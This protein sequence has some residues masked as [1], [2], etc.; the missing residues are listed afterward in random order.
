MDNLDDNLDDNY[1]GDNYDGFKD[2]INE[3]EEWFYFL[4][5]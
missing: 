3:Y 4:E 2:Y 5:I 1:N